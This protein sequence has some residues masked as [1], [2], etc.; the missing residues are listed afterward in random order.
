MAGL[1]TVVTVTLLVAVLREVQFAVTVVATSSHKIVPA[2]LE[3][4]QCF[5]GVSGIDCAFP[6]D[7]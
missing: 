1:V 7:K 4:A 5:T 3:N 6:L 2:N